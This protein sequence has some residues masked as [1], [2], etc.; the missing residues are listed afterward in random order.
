MD[1]GF[2]QPGGGL[3]GGGDRR[4]AGRPRAEDP[5]GLTRH[6]G[7]QQRLGV[8]E[9]ERRPAVLG[10]E[11]GRC[12]ELGDRLRDVAVADREAAEVLLG[13]SSEVV[14]GVLLGE[15]ERVPQIGPGLREPAGVEQRQP[16]VAEQAGQHAV[17]GPGA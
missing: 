17:V 6:A 10:N 15:G 11:V 1:L 4:V 9:G 13:D 2:Q 5:C 8:V 12:G 7:G 3:V 14:E 16:T